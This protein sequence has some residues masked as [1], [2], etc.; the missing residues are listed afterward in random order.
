MLDRILLKIELSEVGLV[1]TRD[2]G[3]ERCLG[4]ALVVAIGINPPKTFVFNFKID[5]PLEIICPAI[6]IVTPWAMIL[7][8]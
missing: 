5:F 7:L 2:I 4:K 1:L 3:V 6:V 8:S